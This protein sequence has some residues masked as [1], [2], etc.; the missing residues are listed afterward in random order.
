MPNNTIARIRET[1]EFLRVEHDKAVAECDDSVR[2]A[3]ADL[4][5]RLSAEREKC[6]KRHEAVCAEANKEA[7]RTVSAAENEAFQKAQELI[8]E[9]SMKLPEA[10]RIIVGR[11]IGRWR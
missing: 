4:E 2:R 10:T 1:E 3:K 9:R 7:Q 11:I 5:L 6:A 8:H